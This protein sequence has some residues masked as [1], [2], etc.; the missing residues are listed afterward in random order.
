MSFNARCWMQ[1]QIAL[2]AAMIL[3]SGCA[4]VGFDRPPSACP[5]VVEYSRA[6]QA[7]VVEELAALT[8][9]AMI[10]EWLPATIAAVWREGSSSH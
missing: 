5:P 7:R 2:A 4:G 8:N 1:P 3:L 10:T 6:E 9:G